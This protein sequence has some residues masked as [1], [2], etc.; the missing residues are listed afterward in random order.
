MPLLFELF[1]LRG[2]APGKGIDG[3]ANQAVRFFHRMSRLIDEADL[4]GLPTAAQRLGLIARKQRHDRFGFAARSSGPEGFG[5]PGF[6][7]YFAG[8]RSGGLTR[9]FRK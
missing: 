8:R 9:R 4:E 3:F 5:S 1:A 7:S 6:R 2:K